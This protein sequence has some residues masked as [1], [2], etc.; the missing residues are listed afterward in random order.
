MD[1]MYDWMS[2]FSARIDEIDYLLTTNR[3]WVQRTKDIGIVTAEDALNL[4]FR[5]VQN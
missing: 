4:G 5:F 2:K 3:I 1:D